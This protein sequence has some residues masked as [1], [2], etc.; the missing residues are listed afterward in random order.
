MATT[1]PS[2]DFQ[3]DALNPVHPEGGR[4]SGPSVFIRTLR[5]NIRVDCKAWFDVSTAFP[6]TGRARPH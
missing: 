1:A 5:E 6:P 4:I 3:V 2:P